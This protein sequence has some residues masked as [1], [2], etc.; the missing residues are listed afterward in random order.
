MWWQWYYSV[1]VGVFCLFTA[2]LLYDKSTLTYVNLAFGVLN[3]LMGLTL[4]FGR[5]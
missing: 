1:A 2:I 3:I 4:Y 5:K